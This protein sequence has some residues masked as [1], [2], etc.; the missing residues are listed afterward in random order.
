[1]VD[2]GERLRNT[3]VRTLSRPEV[4]RIHFICGTRTVTSSLFA[5]VIDRL[6]KKKLHIDNDPDDI[7]A[8]SEAQYSPDLNL[9]RFNSPFYGETDFEQAV[10]V[11]ESVHAGFDVIG[12]G[13][14]FLQIDD[15]PSG[16]LAESFFLLNL[17]YSFDEIRHVLPLQLAFTIA[18]NMRSNKKVSVSPD[19]LMFLRNGIARTRITRHG[20]DTR[21]GTDKDTYRGIPP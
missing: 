3:I 6:H 4:H 13:S 2:P 9:F 20:V 1:M 21:K 11:H 8:G 7:G 17:G 12:H 10:I 19:D 16:Y 14:R 18:L 5:A 15:E